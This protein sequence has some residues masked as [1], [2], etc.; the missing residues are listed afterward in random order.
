MSDPEY[1][2]V[3]PGTYGR[4]KD[5]AVCDKCGGI[6]PGFIGMEGEWPCDCEEGDEAKNVSHL[7][8]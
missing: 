2:A 7:R 4:V 5:G 8:N 6:R 1:N 3:W